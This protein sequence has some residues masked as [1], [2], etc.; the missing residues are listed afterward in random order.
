MRWQKKGL[1]YCPSGRYGWDK[2]SAITPTP[3]LLNDETIRI[4][5]GF[6]DDEGISRIGYIDVKSSDPSKV[7][8]VSRKPVLDIGIPGTFD[9]NGVIL[10]DVIKYKKKIRMYY[11]GFQLVKKTKFLAFSGL[12][13]SNDGG[14][15]FKRVSNAPILDRADEGLYIRA[16]HSVRFEDGIWRIWYTAGSKWEYINGKPY[17]SYDIR[18]IESQDGINLN[19][20]EGTIVI[21]NNEKEFR[22]GRPRVYRFNGKYYMFYTKGIKRKNGF[23][24]LP[25]YAES[26]DGIH[27]IRKDSE[28]GI[29]PSKKG[30]DSKMICYPSLIR[31][32]NVTYMFYNGNNM[33]KTGVGYAVLEKL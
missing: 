4:Y 6:R 15:T 11:V 1:I 28:I 33:G 5:V 22:I 29:I 9:D 8:G 23:D 32:G 30:W 31:V 17:P 10:G 27:W 19:N 21:P 2:H 20:R 13:I 25:G 3:F 7:V 12:A 16:I 24:Y 26:T 14:Y 18:Y